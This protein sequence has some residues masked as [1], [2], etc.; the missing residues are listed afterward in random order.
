MPGDLA[1]EAFDD[2]NSLSVYQPPVTV[3]AQ[4]SRELGREAGKRLLARL[5]GDKSRPKHLQLPP[6]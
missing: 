6:S 5:Q 2:L 4:A 3:V 1:V